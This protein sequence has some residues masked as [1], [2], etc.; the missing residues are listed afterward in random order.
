MSRRI[1]VWPLGRWSTPTGWRLQKQLAAPRAA[2]QVGDTLLCSST[3][4]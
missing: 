4:R 1:T 3:R 2:G